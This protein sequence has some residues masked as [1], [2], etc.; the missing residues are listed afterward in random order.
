[1]FKKHSPYAEQFKNL[2]HFDGLSDT[3]V[4]KIVDNSTHVTLPKDW[5][6][7][8]E[9]Q[10]ADKAYLILDGEVSV[11]R[12]GQEVARLGPGDTIGEVAIVRHSL[13][14]ATVISITPLELLH[15]TAEAVEAL[16]EEIP[17]FKAALQATSDERIAH[18]REG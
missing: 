9:Q 3:Q 6:L 10:P 12:S 5:A 13:R 18:D 11:R 8:S 16:T 17:Q 7:I 2:S 14:T 15:F 4:Q 1:M